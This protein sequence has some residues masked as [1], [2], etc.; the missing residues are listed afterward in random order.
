MDEHMQGGSMLCN[1][2]GH[3]C[4]NAGGQGHHR[5]FLLRLLL[6][7]III[8]MV[9]SLGVKVGEF[10]GAFDVDGYGYHMR[11]MMYQ[12]QYQPVTSPKLQ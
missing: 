6:G 8:A 4:G 2:C 10:K 5:F 12:N 1:S 9:F 7:L 11:P 3:G